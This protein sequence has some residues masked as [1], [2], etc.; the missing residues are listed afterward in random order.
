MDMVKA[1]NGLC[2]ICGA[3]PDELVVDH[4][5]ASGNVR[6]LLC[7]SCNLGLGKFFDNTSYLSNAINYLSNV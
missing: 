5:H 6:G 7:H 4:C 2:A 1:Q 3:E